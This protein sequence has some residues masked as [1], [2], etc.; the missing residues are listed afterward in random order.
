MPLP[1]PRWDR[2][3]RSL[4]GRPIPPVS[5]FADD[6]GLP[7][8][9]GG[10][11]PTLKLSRPA[12]HSLALRPVD[13]LHR[14]AV[15]VS[16]RLRRLCY[17][18]RRSDSFRPERPSWPGGAYTRW[19][20]T[21]LPRRTYNDILKKIYKTIDINPGDATCRG[22]LHA[23]TK[24]CSCTC[25]EALQEDPARSVRRHESG[26]RGAVGGQVAGRANSIPCKTS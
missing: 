1:L 3:V 18:H 21:A 8:I 5:L 6:G 16:R 12:Q 15:H 4:M 22:R 19:V 13:A 25:K 2:R 10:S 14:Q 24:C 26:R 20:D 9:Y 7:R 17:L 23:P 11:A